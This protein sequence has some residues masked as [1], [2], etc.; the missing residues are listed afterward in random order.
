MKNDKPGRGAG[1]SQDFKHSF[2]VSQ[3]PELSL[4]VYNVGFQK[5]PPDYGWGPGVRD[6]FLLHYIVSGR[7]TYDSGGRTFVLGPGDAFLARPDTPIYYRADRTD[8]WEY[9]WVGFSGPSAALLLAQTPFSASRPVLHLA[10]GDRLRRALLDIYKARGADYPSAVR[11]AGYLQAALGLLMD[12]A[13]AHGTDALQDYARR[14]DSFIQQNYS[15]DIS[16]EA[17]AAHVGVSRSYLH[18]AFRSVFGCA[19]G[20]YLT[21][22]RLDRA[23]Q[24]L[25]H[26]GLSV[27]AVAASVGF[28]DPFYFSRLFRRRMGM[29]PS[30]YRLEKP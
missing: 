29:S 14:G 18:R 27:G 21:D 15:R 26:S 2:K 9:Y 28:A 5:C 25:R 19:P 22:Y 8:P 20:A 7:G 13:P 24:L 1:M 16:V 17:V 4:T 10:A 6:H 11:M 12:A 23:S 3:R 30:D